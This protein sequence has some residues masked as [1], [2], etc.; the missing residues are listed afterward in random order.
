[1]LPLVNDRFINTADVEALI[2]E[3][4]QLAGD[5]LPLSC[6]GCPLWAHLRLWAVKTERRLSPKGTLKIA[7]WEAAIGTLQ[8][9]K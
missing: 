6:D 1:M 8:T 4:Q 9:L 5:C 7:S 2:Y 3:C